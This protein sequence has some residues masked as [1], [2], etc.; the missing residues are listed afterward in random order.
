MYQI[1]KNEI[2]EMYVDLEVLV[3]G[4]DWK[5]ALTAATN[6][7]ASSLT[8]K[9]FRK[10]KVPADIAKSYI[11]PQQLLPEAIKAIVNQALNW[12]IKETKLRPHYLDPRPIYDIVSVTENAATLKYTFFVGP[13]VS[14]GQ[15]QD[16]V[17]NYTPE[18]VD[19]SR[20]DELIAELQRNNTEVE[21]V[22]RA[23]ALGDYVKIDFVGK[24]DGVAFEGGTASNYELGLGT[25]TF[26]PGFEEQLVGAKA[27]DKVEVNVTFPTNYQA[28]HLAGKE[29]VFDVTVHEVN[30]HS[31]PPI[32]DE[33]ASLANIEGIATMQGLR[34]Y[35]LEELQNAAKQEAKG[36]ELRTLLDQV[37]NS[38]TI[39][40]PDSLIDRHVQ[41]YLHNI[42]EEGKKKG[43]T[44][45]D[46]LASQKDSEGKPYAS[47]EDFIN[48]N[49]KDRIAD[50]LKRQTILTAIIEKENLQLTDQ[51]VD[52][53]IKALAA[54]NKL[55]E[56]QVRQYIQKDQRIL[57]QMQMKK[58]EDFLL[59]KNKFNP[60][61]Q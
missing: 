61:S 26:I 34:N 12:A 54:A 49:L 2:K 19:E 8:V 13:E 25:K 57:E 51:D 36:K 41:Q 5:K 58:L 33:L 6:K 30:V 39:T 27:G 16:L 1:V 9:G 35:Y 17:V 40:L 28:A 31:L 32:D 20:V 18:V 3:D 45:D 47:L 7:L 38:S 37:Y 60:V 44:I 24:L 52:S 10:G 46:Y 50:N 21:S 53:E 42:E 43:K 15:Y 59:A 55:T 14:L 29:V 22:D 48:R 56:D 23:A 11:K 4:E